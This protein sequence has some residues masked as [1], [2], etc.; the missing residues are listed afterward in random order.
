LNAEVAFATAGN[1]NRVWALRISNRKLMQGLTNELL[2]VAVYVEVC[3]PRVLAP[4]ADGQQYKEPE[5]P[6]LLHHDVSPPNLFNEIG[7]FL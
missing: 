5:K 1:R 2:F 7:V 6:R 3:S 4:Q